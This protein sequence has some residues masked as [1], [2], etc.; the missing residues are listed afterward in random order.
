MCWHIGNCGCVKTILDMKTW[1][2]IKRQIRVAFSSVLSHC[3]TCSSISRLSGDHGWQRTGCQS[4][5]CTAVAPLSSRHWIRMGTFLT[6]HDEEQTAAGRSRSATFI[7]LDMGHLW[8]RKML[9]VVDGS[10]LHNILKWL[11]EPLVRFINPAINTNLVFLLCLNSFGK[12]DLLW[13]YMIIENGKKE[14]IKPWNKLG[15]YCEHLECSIAEGCVQ[16]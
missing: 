7:S 15:G 14:K 2:G 12:T 6:G 1:G 11:S 13:F 3:S 8:G 9:S 10:S 16:N 5:V 4:G